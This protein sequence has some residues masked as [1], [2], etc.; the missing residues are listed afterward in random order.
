MVPPLPEDLS[1]ALEKL[2]ETDRSLVSLSRSF[3]LALL[4]FP[5]VEASDQE[6]IRQMLRHHFLKEKEELSLSE[7]REIMQLRSSFLESLRPLL[8]KRCAHIREHV[9]QED[10]SSTEFMQSPEWKILNYYLQII[11]SLDLAI[12]MC[13]ESPRS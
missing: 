11:S 13:G 9:V 1:R 3:F 10:H 12:M 5:L 8:R 4:G 2:S 6:T 7:F